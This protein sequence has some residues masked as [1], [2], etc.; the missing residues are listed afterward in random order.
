MSNDKSAPAAA[1]D[2]SAGAAASAPATGDAAAPAPATA[3]AD[4]PAAAPDKVELVEVVALEPGHDGRVYRR[5]GERFHVPS[6]RLKDGTTWFV[7]AD[8]A[9]APA[10]EK[11]P[12]ARP[13]GAGP[14]RGSAVTD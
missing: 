10:K 6:G 3:D 13:P 11:A 1:P 8:K 5:T 9:P 4:A 2:K 7:K 12:A 14:L